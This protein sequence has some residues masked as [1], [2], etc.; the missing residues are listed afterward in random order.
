MVQNIR[1]ILVVALV[2]A[3]L[4]YLAVLT[5][6]GGMLYEGFAS[7]GAAQPEFTLFWMNGCPHCESIIGDY[8]KFAAAGQF[9]ANGKKVKIRE[10]EQSEA[11]PLLNQKGV[12]GFPT[13][14]LTLADGTDVQYTG[15][16]TVKGYKEFI[17]SK[18]K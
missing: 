8:K 18:V 1:I 17:V 13:F 2:V 15:E 16:R 10:L 3:I 11:G 7:E 5:S 14:I 9:E 6:G 4:A 12:D